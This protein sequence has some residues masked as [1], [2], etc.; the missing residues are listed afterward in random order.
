MFLH[1]KAAQ[2]TDHDHA[3]QLEQ[4]VDWHDD[5]LQQQLLEKLNKSHNSTPA[6]GGLSISKASRRQRGLAR[7]SS[8]QQA[9]LPP[10]GLDRDSSPP[11]D[12]PRLGVHDLLDELLTQAQRTAADD[13]TAAQQQ[14][15]RHGAHPQVDQHQVQQEQQGPSQGQLL[16]NQQQVSCL[17][18]WCSMCYQPHIRQ[19]EHAGSLCCHLKAAPVTC[20]SLTPREV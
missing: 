12:T 6:R 3:E 17:A 20:R 9:L 14:P 19:R 2:D 15:A 5:G 8:R 10:A 18:G 11:Q 1:T 13:N 4:C 16:G 7:S